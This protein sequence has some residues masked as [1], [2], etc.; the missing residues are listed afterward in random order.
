VRLDRDLEWDEIAGVIEDAWLTVA[1]K[2]LVR[3]Y[4]Q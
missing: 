1:P 3:G 2:R 4:D